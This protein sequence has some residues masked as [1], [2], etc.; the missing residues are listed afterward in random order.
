MEISNK[1]QQ[2]VHAKFI[3]QAKRMGR[4]AAHQAAFSLRS[5]VIEAYAYRVCKQIIMATP[6]LAHDVSA[7]R[8][9]VLQTRFVTA[10]LDAY[11]DEIICLRD[12][13]CQ[14]VGGMSMSG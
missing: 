8:D 7:S 10:Y 13:I 3:D 12:R 1:T 6:N 4:E 11:F 5:D 9:M 14:R 2:D